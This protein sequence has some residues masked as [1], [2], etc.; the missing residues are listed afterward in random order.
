MGIDASELSELGLHAV[1]L[2]PRSPRKRTF[3]E[4]AGDGAPTVPKEGDVAQTMTEVRGSDH[5]V[6]LPIL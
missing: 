5:L 4:A 6:S 1:P 3:A 2:V